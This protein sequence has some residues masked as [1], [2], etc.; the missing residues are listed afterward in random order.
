MDLLTKGRHVVTSNDR[1]QFSA[2][3]LVMARN[4]SMLADKIAESMT[5]PAQGTDDFKTAGFDYDTITQF[6]LTGYQAA[7]DGLESSDRIS[8]VKGY[9]ATPQETANL[10]T[11][12]NGLG[13]PAPNQISR[14]FVAG[15]VEG[16]RAVVISTNAQYLAMNKNSALQNN[17]KL[18]LKA[19]LDPLLATIE[20]KQKSIDLITHGKIN[21]V[22]SEQVL[23]N[24]YQDVVAAT[25]AADLAGLWLTV[26]KIL[27]GSFMLS[28]PLD[29]TGPKGSKFNPAALGTPAVQHAMPTT[30]PQP[31]AP[32][33]PRRPFNPS[34]LNTPPV[35][36]APQTPKP[37]GKPFDPANLAPSQP[38]PAVQSS[39]NTQPK[40]SFDPN[41]LKSPEK[42]SFDPSI[43]GKPAVESSTEPENPEP[44]KPKGK[45]FDPKDL[46]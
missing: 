18:R 45:S 34:N 30:P 29:E 17:M 14:R 19:Q 11:M 20:A 13:W 16:L 28:Q 42:R 8:A 37:A 25:A 38:S 21:D 5:N 44:P 26:P 27:D 10:Q 22:S 32:A 1:Y 33:G 2:A 43:L 6:L 46:L 24:V 40:R 35:T 3:Y 41:A 36:P 12:L 4:R 39:A 23:H 31:T 15:A 9:Q 7:T